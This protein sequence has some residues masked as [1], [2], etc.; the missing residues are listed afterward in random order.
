MFY[1]DF[2]MLMLIMRTLLQCSLCVYSVLC[3]LI[4]YVVRTLLQYSICVLQ[5]SLYVDSL[6]S[7]NS[8]TIFYVCCD[9]DCIASSVFAKTVDEYKQPLAIA[10]ICFYV[11][12]NCLP[13]RP[14]YR[15]GTRDQGFLHYFS[16]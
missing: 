9:D 7:E 13:C 12:P 6:C 4:V 14:L 2:C 10:C 5:C 8:V 15:G 16:T 1:S 11:L 3:M